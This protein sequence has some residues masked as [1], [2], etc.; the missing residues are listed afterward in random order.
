MS[1]YQAI[2]AYFEQDGGRKVTMEELKALGKENADELAGLCA[3][4]LGV[5]LKS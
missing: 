4:E 2:R 5:T 1:K 3:I